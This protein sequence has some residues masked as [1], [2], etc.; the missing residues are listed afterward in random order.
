M[1][2]KTIVATILLY[3]LSI[4]IFI[5]LLRVINK[6][7]NKSFLHRVCSVN[8]SLI[9][10]WTFFSFIN[11]I[12]QTLYGYSIKLIY[13]FGSI[14][15][16]FLPST[17]VF[18]SIVLI[19]GHIR[20]LRRYIILII[21]PIIST[22]LLLTNDCHK[23]F[24][25]INSTTDTIKPGP[26]FF[27]HCAWQLAFAVFAIC[28]IIYYSLKYTKCLSAQILIV[29][30]GMSVPIFVDIIIFL[31]A[32]P[33][34]NLNINRH[35]QM[36][37]YCI[38]TI[39]LTYAIYKYRFLEVVPIAIRNVIDHISDSFI[40]IDQ[41]NDILEINH[42]FKDEFAGFIDSSCNNLFDLFNNSIFN[43]F[44]K[45][46]IELI[47]LAAKEHRS[48]KFEHKFVMS[49]SKYFSIEITP[50]FINK[51]F[52][53]SLILFK[54]TTEHMRVLEL[55]EENAKQL[56]ETARLTSLN[57]LIGG[58]AHNI[59]SPLMSSSGG[60][61][62]LENN[63]KKLVTLFNQLKLD[64]ENSQHTKILEDMQKWENMIKQYLIYISDIITAVKDQAV[65]LNST[66][67][68]TF[69]FKEIMDKVKLL[70]DFELKKSGCKL[71]Q[72]IDIDKDFEIEGDITAL[73]QILNNIIIN[74]IQ[75]YNSGGIIDMSVKEVS[76]YTA[77][78]IK[79]YG[80]GIEGRIKDKIFNEMVTTKGKD[81]A[82][83]GLYI[84]N[85]AIKSHFRG[86]ID[87]ESEVDKGTTVY[88]MLPKNQLING[89]T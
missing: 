3:L 80:K 67:N 20:L 86:K 6:T 10:L 42:V 9:L 14:S 12:F 39:C 72:S 87:I 38:C 88:V 60:V 63:T 56:L 49:K 65:S 64:T 23:L 25:E 74:A 66:A 77:F 55:M 18:L 54:N 70:M 22:L 24:P 7:A 21:P 27:A 52:M 81:G 5:F 84:S 82:G 35:I 85:I 41:K 89:N 19:N 48:I 83:I 68:K 79:D 34:K 46:T 43:E 71:N 29:T 59:K 58:I 2:Y 13:I 26:V 50:I 73:T 32:L 28:Y 69:T 51:R 1:P 44:I 47:E 78:V 30:I 37:S 16:F 17:L 8:V 33:T 57:Q 53:A 15:V 62:V 31:N 75:S 11:Y 61:L 36:I 4:S 76:Q 40:I 45:K